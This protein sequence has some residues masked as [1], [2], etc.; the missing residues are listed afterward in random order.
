[1]KKILILFVI[2]MTPLLFIT[3]CG[4][5]KEKIEY[6]TIELSDDGYGFKT[7]FKYDSSLTFK[8]IEY[9]D[10][11]KSK[12]LEFESE[13]LGIDFSMYYNDLGKN[14]AED[15]KTS[16][17]KMKY[18]KE[19]KFNGHDAYC[20]GDYD[21]SLNMIIRLKEDKNNVYY[22]LFISM[23]S[24]DVDTVVYDVLT[25]NTLQ[26]FFNSIEF[27]ENRL[28]FEMYFED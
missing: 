10:E 18:Y 26:E 17:S 5:E 24:E 6:K 20:Y 14:I 3:G 16:R 21:D 8:D 12:E 23:E 1:M 27:E 19:F 11:G 22:N 4:K 28:T 13:E 7:T 9:N 2:V 25:Q 15:T